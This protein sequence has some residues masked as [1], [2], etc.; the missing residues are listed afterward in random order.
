M[1]Q[2]PAAQKPLP[3][4]TP[5]TEPFWEGTKQHK[6]MIQY[7]NDCQQ[8]Y[9]YPRPYCR[10]CLSDNVEWRQVSG[11]A[12][13]HTFVVNHRPAPGFDNEAPYVI[14]IMELAEGPRMMSNLVGVDANEPER[15]LE[16]ARKKQPFEVVFEAA[17]EEI[18]LPKF[19]PVGA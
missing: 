13:L 17:N 8:Y 14:A 19:R 5:E 1:A 16:M 2:R 4:P 6:L 3:R 10:H 12:T 11:R 7:C 15:L 18:T 9:F